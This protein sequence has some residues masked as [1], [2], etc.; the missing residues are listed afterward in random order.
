MKAAG[1]HTLGSAPRF[2]Q[3]PDP[4]P[5][6][7]EV[8]VHVRAAA[9]K[10][11]D[12]QIADGSHYSSPRELPVVCGIDGVG[13]LDDGTRVF[14]GGPRRPYGAMAELAVVRRTQCFPVPEGLS[15]DV[16]AAVPNPGVSAWL[17][18]KWRA[19][20]LPGETGLILGATGVPGQPA[21][22]VA[23]LLGA[24][25]VIA[26]GRN[27]QVLDALGSRGADAVI[28]L[29]DSEANVTAAF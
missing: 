10:P 7:N 29:D 4:E 9:L 24:Q 25:R 27:K 12:K 11:V 15:D 23:K 26:A 21:V 5:D 2:E 1:L 8:I 3:F 17:S 14:F 28:S 19:R 13:L 22:Q 20:L 18:L 16:A 6:E